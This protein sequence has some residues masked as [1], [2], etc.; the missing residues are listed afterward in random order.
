MG[1]WCQMDDGWMRRDVTISLKN[2]RGNFIQHLCSRLISLLSFTLHLS[3]SLS[4]VVYPPPLIQ[5]WTQVKQVAAMSGS[6][7]K[8]VG[9]FFGNEAKQVYSKANQETPLLYS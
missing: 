4:T 9:F 6:E 5:V 7:S 1:V 8:R 2:E 3:L